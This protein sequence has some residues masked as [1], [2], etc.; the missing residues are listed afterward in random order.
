MKTRLRALFSRWHPLRRPWLQFSPPL[1]LSSQFLALPASPNLPLPTQPPALQRLYRRAS[2]LILVLIF[3][4]VCWLGLGLFGVSAPAQA[5]VSNED[6]EQFF[7]VLDDLFQKGLE[8]TQAGDFE[9]AEDYWSAAIEIYPQN[10]AAWSNRGNVRVSQFKLDEAIDDFNKAVELAPNLP[11]PYINRGT[12][13]EGLKE[14]EKAIDD[15][16]YAITLNPRD[17]VAYNNR[18]NAQGGAGNWEAASQDFQKA[19][20]LAPGF[21]GANVNYAL[22]LYQLGDVKESTRL[23]RGL[24][25]RYSQFAD[26]RAALT[27]VLWGQGLSGEAESNWYPVMGLDPRYSDTDWLLNIRRWPPQ[28]VEDLGRFLALR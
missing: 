19:A 15:Y 8:A 1:P 10:P 18:G 26:P 28:V 20:V 3:S 6:L 14:W 5:A 13:W 23:L 7:Q 27:A 21:A 4:S 11:D 24:V 16:N 25:R 12:A 17:P 22:S 9:V 2:H